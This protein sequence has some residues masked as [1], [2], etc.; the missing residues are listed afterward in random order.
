MYEHIVL[1]GGSSMYPGLPSRLEKEL[2][3]LY[4]THVLKGNEEGMRKL[5]LKIE[6]PPRRKHMARC[7]VAALLLL[8]VAL[9]RASPRGCCDN[10]PVLSACPAA[11]PRRCSWA[12]RC[13]RT[14]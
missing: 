7:A 13:W 6:D 3:R 5:K 1:S 12:R 8:C 2:R 9:L 10:T 11:R 14:S 4:L